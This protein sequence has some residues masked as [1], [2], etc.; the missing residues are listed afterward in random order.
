VI[1]QDASPPSVARLCVAIVVEQRMSP[2]EYAF[3]R[4]QSVLSHQDHLG[5]LLNN[6]SA[7]PPISELEIIL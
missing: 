5:L 2:C 7:V 3:D 6:N 1:A 4:P